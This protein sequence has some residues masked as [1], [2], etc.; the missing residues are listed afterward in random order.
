MKKSRN[1][2]KEAVGAKKVTS[3]AKRTAGKKPTTKAKTKVKKSATK[4]SPIK[5]RPGT[6][7]EKTVARIQQMM[8][9]RSTVSHDEWLVD[10]VGNRRQYDVVIRGRFAGRKILGIIECK[11]HSR[12]KGP[13]AIEAFAKKAENLNANFKV[14]VSKKGFTDQALKLAKHEGI[15]CLS[16]LPDDPKQVGFGIGDMWYAKLY[17]WRAIRLTV[18][19]VRK[20]VTIGSVPPASV[21]WKGQ[22]VIEWFIK[23][24]MTTGSQET[25]EG[26][27][28]ITLEFDRVRR[29][30]VNG[31]KYNVRGLICTA[32]RVCYKKKRWV[33]W[34]GD[35]F[36]DWH[37]GNFTI[38]PKGMIVSSSIDTHLEKW[39]DFD[40]DI[41]EKRKGA[42]AG[43]LRAVLYGFQK[44]DDSRRV[45]DLTKL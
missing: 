27:H 24:L 30:E 32:N 1:V 7:L 33:T 22:P 39:D 42:P 26:N 2:R 14:V 23:E 11:D 20:N 10:R 18:L 17:K 43:F 41:P 5:E 12:K 4:S 6:S 21:K 44:Q 16:L 37:A 28:T 35:A 15:G 9:P 8:D 3:R 25:R 34:S 29:I 36:Y 45:V 19:F 31:K 13:A 40:G 38:P